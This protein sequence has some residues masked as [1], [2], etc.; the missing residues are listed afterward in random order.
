MDC[1]GW[2]P[3]GGAAA[4]CC[5]RWQS[6]I[7]AA[8]GEEKMKRLRTS[9][10][11]SILDLAMS[12]E[13]LGADDQGQDEDEADDDSISS[14]GRDSTMSDEGSGDLLGAVC[15]RGGRPERQSRPSAAAAASSSRARPA[16]S[17]T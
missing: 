3:R 8:Q 13:L 2:R 16:S 7:R 11:S 10:C 15:K 4:R 12:T 14:T 5:G 6:M 1:P 9:I 17:G